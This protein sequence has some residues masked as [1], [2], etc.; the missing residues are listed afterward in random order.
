MEKVFCVGD[1]VFHRENDDYKNYKLNKDYT[2]FNKN[3]YDWDYMYGNLFI[4]LPKN[5]ELFEHITN[6]NNY[7]KW[8]N[9]NDCKNKLIK[10]FIGYYNEYNGNKIG[11]S[12]YLEEKDIF[13]DQWFENLEIW[14]TTLTILEDGKYY[15]S[16][17][18]NGRYHAELLKI[19]T[20]ED[21]INSM[22]YEYM[23]DAYS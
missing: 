1:F 6:I 10:Y 16:I 5:I 4:E 17:T 13:I 14:G 9:S 2:V 12:D 11:E 21:N 7:I 8:L 22:E 15:C 18:C 19:F 23:G 20:K 3:I